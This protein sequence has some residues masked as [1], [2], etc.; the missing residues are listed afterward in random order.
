M[1]GTIDF[2]GLC[3]FV[4]ETDHIRVLLPKTAD[5]GTRKKHEAYFVDRR[6]ATPNGA[7]IE[8][9][10]EHRV[11]FE[12][13]GT[14][15]PGTGSLTD[16]I[17]LDQV[18]PG[19]TLKRDSDLEELV[20]AQIILRGGRL[21]IWKKAPR[22]PDPCRFVRP[23]YPTDPID[24]KVEKPACVMRWTP[25]QSEFDC[26]FER[27]AA[28]PFRHRFRTSSAAPRRLL[29][30]NVCGQPNPAK[31]E[32]EEVSCAGDVLDHDY[33]W[34]YSLFDYSGDELLPLASCGLFQRISRTGPRTGTTSTCYNGGFC[35][36]GPC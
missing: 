10:S 25:G 9:L 28:P 26:V 35:P 22:G 5:A 31:W 36:G 11:T 8:P 32:C 7:L 2:F 30:G 13:R 6:R 27:K 23:T 12:T 21:A 29:I 33:A 14:G 15:R 24:Y 19:M 3:L 18:C 1:S 4:W 16:L 20:E 34:Y 17:W